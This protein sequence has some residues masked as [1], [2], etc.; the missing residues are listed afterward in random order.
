MQV[1]DTIHALKIPF[2]IPVSPEKQI[3]RVVYAFLIFG[4]KITLIDSGVSGADKLIFEYIEKNGRDPGKVHTLILSHSHPDHIGSA[5]RIKEKTGCRILAHPAEKNWI[6]DT[7]KQA[8]E[9]P[10]PGFNLLVDGPVAIDGLLE[11]NETV[12][13]EDAI[14][15]QVFHT[16]GHSAGSLSLHLAKEKTL[17]TGDALPLPG[18]LPIYD[19]ITACMQSIKKLHRLSEDV[20]ILLSS[21]EAPIHGNENIRTRIMAGV[22]YLERI[23]ETVMEAHEGNKEN[24]MKL[25]KEVVTALALPPFAANPLVARAFASSLDVSADENLFTL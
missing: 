11:N 7:E 25:C 13:L 5:Q 16:P 8:R 14:T 21:W 20:E 24:I 2:Q 17:F 3:T 18:D 12:S 4:E 10:V 6:E 22:D 23:H 9:R 15:C 1:N 19:D